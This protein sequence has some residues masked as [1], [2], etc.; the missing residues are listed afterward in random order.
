MFDRYKYT[1][2]FGKESCSAEYKAVFPLVTKAILP[3]QVH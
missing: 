3:K 1:F 2:I